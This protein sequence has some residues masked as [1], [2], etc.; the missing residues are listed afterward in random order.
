LLYL[1]PKLVYSSKYFASCIHKLE[2]KFSWMETWM[3]NL[4]RVYRALKCTFVLWMHFWS[5]KDIHREV[6]IYNIDAGRKRIK[7]EVLLNKK[8]RE[9]YTNRW[10]NDEISQGSS[11]LYFL[12]AWRN[13]FN[14]RE[15]FNPL[16]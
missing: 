11:E 14:K 8:L 4:Y 15:G 10:D 1:P 12:R 2:F 3:Q 5:M 9:I 13:R 16:N 7:E 6:H